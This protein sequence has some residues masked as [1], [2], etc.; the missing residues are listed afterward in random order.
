MDTRIAS[1]KLINKLKELQDISAQLQ[2]EKCAAD[3]QTRKA[4][5]V[6]ILL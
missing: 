1:T 4:Q 2:D 5:Q 6:T 3:V